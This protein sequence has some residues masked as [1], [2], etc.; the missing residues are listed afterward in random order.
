MKL[1]SRVLAVA[2]V[3]VISTSVAQA[4]DRTSAGVQ[5]DQRIPEETFVYFSIPSVNTMKARM[6]TKIHRAC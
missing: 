3:G 6:A 5:A 4:Q 1:S 2:I